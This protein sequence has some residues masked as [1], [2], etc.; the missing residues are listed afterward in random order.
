MSAAS[1]PGLLSTSAL[2]KLIFFTE[3]G[4]F[5]TSIPSPF[6][7]RYLATSS[8]FACILSPMS[9]LAPGAQLGP[10]RVIELLGA[11]GMG[12]V[13]RAQDTR[14]GRTVALKLL[15]E[16][17]SLDPERRSRM[18]QEAQT[19]S[20]L[21][22][23]HIMT[24]HDLAEAD[25]HQFLVLEYVA[26]RTLDQVI[27]RH[28]LPLEDAV[29]YAAQIASALAAAHEAGVIHRD[30]K[31]ANI[32]VTDKGAVKLLDF[33]LAKMVQPVAARPAASGETATML[34]TEP[35]MVLGTVNYM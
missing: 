16:E 35:G 25:G 15:P 13:Y 24:L 3:T 34:Q 12:E 23:P 21:N 8:L 5:W 27:P 1:A 33:G 4:M 22:H 10:Y 29:R 7:P 31:P 18:L 26:G 19:V 6:D 11:G 28:G 17:R 32:M 30:L 14:L 9:R 2:H 20:A